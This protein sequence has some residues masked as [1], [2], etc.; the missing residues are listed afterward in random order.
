MIFCTLLKDK[1]N[2]NK[3]PLFSSG[4]EENPFSPS[5]SE[6]LSAVG[7]LLGPICKKLA[8]RHTVTEDICKSAQDVFLRPLSDLNLPEILI[9]GKVKSTSSA[10]TFSVLS[11]CVNSIISTRSNASALSHDNP[12]AV[13]L[14]VRDHLILYPQTQLVINR[15]HLIHNTEEQGLSLYRLPCQCSPFPSLSHCIP[16]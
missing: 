12:R 6:G 16:L 2:K 8:A 11:L 5:L 4:C 7:H 9:K 10:I 14:E 1:K 15:L 13:L 3:S